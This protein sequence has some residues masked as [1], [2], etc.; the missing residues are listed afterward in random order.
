MDIPY[1]G[2]SFVTL[3]T[4]DLIA[5]GIFRTA[6]WVGMAHVDPIIGCSFFFNR[7]NASFQP[8]AIRRHSAVIIMRNLAAPAKHQAVWHFSKF[9]STSN[10]LHT[11]FTTLLIWQ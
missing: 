8:S 9:R 5:Y 7:L 3:L 4:T 2:P 1:S 11:P 6:L 10:I